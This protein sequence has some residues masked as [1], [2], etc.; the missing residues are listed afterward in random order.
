[1]VGYYGR[2]TYTPVAAH[3]RTAIKAFV[4]YSVLP[5]GV[6]RWSRVGQVLHSLA[7]RHMLDVVARVLIRGPAWLDITWRQAGAGWRDAVK[8]F[9]SASIRVSRR[10]GRVARARATT[11]WPD[12]YGALS[13]GPGPDSRHNPTTS[14]APPPPDPP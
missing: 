11:P 8:Q 10:R 3:R 4:R 13:H 9:P 2:R 7:Q 14:A 6:L 1:M 12:G 5:L